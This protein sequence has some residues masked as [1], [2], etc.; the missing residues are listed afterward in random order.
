MYILHYVV[1]TLHDGLV[2]VTHRTLFM[3]RQFFKKDVTT[4]KGALWVSTDR[5]FSFAAWPLEVR[6]T[7]IPT[8]NPYL[9][10]S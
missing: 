3:P 1:D 2:S 5:G 6:Q 8:R 4:P 10:R 7:P 9:L